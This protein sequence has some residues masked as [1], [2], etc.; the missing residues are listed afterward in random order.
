[1]CN[2]KQSAKRMELYKYKY[3]YNY[4]FYLKQ[5]RIKLS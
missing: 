2:M 4:I 5:L 3:W 1:M